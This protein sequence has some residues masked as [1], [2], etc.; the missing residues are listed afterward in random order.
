[1]NRCTGRIVPCAIAAALAAIGAA[2]YVDASRLAA[3]D[4][5]NG[6]DPVTTGAVAG[7]YPGGKLLPGEYAEPVF[8][9]FENEKVKVYEVRYGPGER[10]PSSARPAR[11]VR[12]VTGGTV[13]WSYPDGS[14]EK[15][16]WT[17]GQ[18]KWMPRQAF[19]GINVG[20]EP[21]VFF[22]VEPK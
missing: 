20:T 7:N 4:V 6:L 18:T 21:M 10:T 8:T 17:P 22:V 3:Q 16:E 5:E 1:M 2:A 19:A 11:I 12:A 13:V 15:V 14:S 9:F